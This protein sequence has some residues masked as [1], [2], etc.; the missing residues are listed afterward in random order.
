MNNK[1]TLFIVYLGLFISFVSFLL[2]LK[3]NQLVYFISS[4]VTQTQVSLVTAFNYIQTSN[5]YIQAYYNQS[6][7]AYINSSNRLLS[8]SANLIIQNIKEQY[9]LL[10]TTQG[11][12]LNHLTNKI[13]LS[14]PLP[15][16]EPF[17]I[18]PHLL[19]N[20]KI[21][22]DS[23]ELHLP[24]TIVFK[25][26]LSAIDIASTSV[27]QSLYLM[28][29]MG[30]LIFLIGASR[31][32]FIQLQK[33]RLY[34]SAKQN[35]IKQILSPFPVLCLISFLLL[36]VFTIGISNF[37]RN[38]QYTLHQLEESDKTLKM[39]LYNFNSNLTNVC[40]E[41]NL[42]TKSLFQEINYN[43]TNSVTKFNKDIHVFYKTFITQSTQYHQDILGVPLL[44]YYQQ[45][46]PKI[47]LETFQNTYFR[48]NSSF[49][50]L[51]LL[52]KSLYSIYDHNFKEMNL[53]FIMIR[54][55]GFIAL[56]NFILY[57]YI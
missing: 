19:H 54:F 30:V 3:N 39:E 51:P 34:P 37:N 32:Y 56:L 8:A 14:H 2:I 28:M 46:T 26:I 22:L 41:Y 50:K 47:S 15:M 45:G 49:C 20:I 17:L 31:V 24:N 57:K 18:Q 38:Y 10:V 7:N 42:F 11:M 40:D 53:T 36:F 48:F 16:L 29:M 1:T 23:F 6:I 25:N 52:E 35:I 12:L 21:G 27:N 44:D 33:Y 9:N 43:I 5:Q 4:L 13:H 55:S